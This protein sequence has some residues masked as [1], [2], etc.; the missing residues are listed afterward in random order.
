MKHNLYALILKIVIFRYFLGIKY[1]LPSQP[2]MCYTFYTFT[3]KTQH[4]A[5]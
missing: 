3:F 4:F 1:I 5:P 2:L